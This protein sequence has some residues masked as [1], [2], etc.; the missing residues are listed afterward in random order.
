MRTRHTV[1]TSQVLGQDL[2]V[3]M[4]GHGGMPCLVFPSQNGNCRDYAGFGMVEV[5]RPWV[6]AGKL[7]LY[8]VDSLD[9]QTWS[10]YHRPPRERLLRQEAW[11]K[12]LTEEFVPFMYRDSGHTGR[13]MTTGCS[14]GAFHAANIQ[15]R[16]P[17][18]FGTTV[19]LSGA[20]DASW[21]LFQYMDDLVYLNSPVHSI[22][23]MPEG[24]HFINK[25]NDSRIILCCG[26]G[27][28]E[29][30]MLRSLGLLERAM[31]Q[32]GIH[33]WVDRWGHDVNH[34]W[35][36]WRSQLAYFLGI[37]FP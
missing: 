11:M 34:D 2:E 17:D 3:M 33:V 32:K 12:H 18:L 5:A 16:Y 14:M 1:F 35:N 26:Q 37:L 36:W 31:Q 15:F 30:E 23:G 7:Q 24:H 19:A 21:L 20:Y 22:G 13:L 4:Y 29:E 6:E 10:A 9:E 27:A 28:W 8:C 25:Y